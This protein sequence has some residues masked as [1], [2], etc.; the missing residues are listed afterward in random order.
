[1]G[2]NDRIVL[3]HGGG[4]RELRSPGEGDFFVEEVWQE[5]F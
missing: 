4:G 2:G 3:G 5:N 1:M